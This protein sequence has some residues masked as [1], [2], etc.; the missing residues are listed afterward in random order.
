MGLLE[1]NGTVIDINQT[2]MEYVDLDLEDVTGEPFWE[3]PWWGNDDGIQSEVREWI[4]RAASGDY[5][6]FEADLTQPTGE[7]YTVSGYFRP[8]I[9]DGEV[10]SIIVSD[11]DITEQKERERA[12][13]DA[14]AQLEA[15]TE[16]AA[17]GTWEW[18]VQEDMM[19]MGPSFATRFGIDPDDAREGISLDRYVSAIHEDDRERVE[20]MVDEALASCGEYEEEY[21]VWNDEGEL[22]WVVARGR[23]ECDEDGNPLTFPGAVTDITERKE[24]QHKLEESNERLEQFAYAASHDL[25]EPLRMVSSYLQL[26]EHRYGDEL[27]ED[28]QEFI[29]FAVDGA[30]RM[31]EM[32]EGLLQ[33]S[34]VDSRGNPFEP[35]DLDAVFANVRQDLQVKIEETGA[36]ITAEDLPRVYGD[37]S[38]LNQLFQNLLDNAIEYSGD[39]PP[40]IHVA[41]ERDGTD[42]VISVEDEGIGIPREDADR[43]FRVFQSLQGHEDAGTGIGLALCKRIVERHGG[44]IWIDSVPGEGA[45]FSFILPAAGEADE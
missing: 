42:W 9:D 45:T 27:D 7:N 20:A 28:G 33:Y 19:V 21:R 11:R 17:V 1:P 8:V 31:R 35:V 41:V 15:A 25:Q 5:V 23:V 22:R 39:A 12:L 6:D 26:L 2:A 10:V 29:E 18:H 13:R 38:Q 44:E 43:V 3:T 30:G 4:E 36:E 37:L 40:R 32:I 34:R 14:K 24:Y 16:A